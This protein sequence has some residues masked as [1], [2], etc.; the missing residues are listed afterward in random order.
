[1]MARLPVTQHPT[2]TAADAEKWVADAYQLSLVGG[3]LM[4]ATLQGEFR[5]GL[6]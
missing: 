6:C 4:V 2:K 3:V 5:E 1:M